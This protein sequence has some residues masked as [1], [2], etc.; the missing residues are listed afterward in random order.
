M[1]IAYF[2]DLF[3]PSLNG[4]VTSLA[5]L[6]ACL[7]KREHEIIIFAPKPRFGSKVNFKE[8]NVS[9]HYLASIPALAY[10]DFRL[11]SPLTINLVEKIRHVHPDIIHFQTPFSVAGGGILIGKILRRP[12]VG[13]FHGYFMEPEYLAMLGIKYQMNRVSRLLWKYT[14]FFYNQC[15]EVI[16]PARSTMRDINRHGVRKH[17]SIVPN[18]INE[19]KIKL[20]GPK[21]TC[22]LKKKLKLN[23]QV[24]LYVGRLSKEK[25][26]DKL[27]YAFSRLN[28]RLPDTSL[29]LIGEGPERKNLEQ[30]SY[31]LGL[32]G[33]VIFN[34]AVK[35]EKLLTKGYYQIADLFATASTS[36]VQP[37]SI[38]EA[39]YFGLP[40]VGAKKRGVEEMV[41]GVGILANVTDDA[42]LTQAMYQVFADPRLAKTLSEKSIQAYKKIY[43]VAQ[44]SEQYELIYTKLLG[45]KFT[46]D[47]L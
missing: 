39:F 45:K 27:I 7:G 37:V 36:E 40:V 34:G 5:N 38:I 9:V 25:S 31:H 26:L 12:I 15:D 24:A 21:E 13:T 42:L 14:T 6:S 32:A 8:K 29:L 17:L 30:M 18:T 10:P 4:I 43:A 20:A 3:Y 28:K 16:V 44:V 2:T 47:K 35:Q 1:R 11:A 41:K 23:S 19:D 46:P 22:A 33:K